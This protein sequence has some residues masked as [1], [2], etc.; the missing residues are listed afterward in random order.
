MRWGEAEQDSQPV[1]P[2]ELDRPTNTAARLSNQ[3]PGEE[4]RLPI[5]PAVHP[6]RALL[7]MG[8]VSTVL[9][10]VIN[11]VVTIGFH[12]GTPPENLQAI[13]P[14]IAANPYWEIVHHVE[15]VCDVMVLVGFYAVYRSIVVSTTGMSATLARLGIVVAVVAEGIYGAN[16]AV[17]IANK[18]AAQQWVNAPLAEKAAAFGIANAVRHIEIA[19]SSVWTLSAAIALLFFGL[20]IALGRAYPRPLGWAAIALAAVQVANSV[21]LAYN[22]F[23]GTPLTFVSLLLTPWA[24][25]LVVYVWRKAGAPFYGSDHGQTVARG[26]GV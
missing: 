18:F 9:G 25:V 6:E 1:F 12:G 16:Q 14:E 23:V 24:V 26:A 19:T 11:L 8:V 7:R 3:P 4:P 22:G 10:M 15:F 2:E 5:A 17:D 20:A 13:M 21:E